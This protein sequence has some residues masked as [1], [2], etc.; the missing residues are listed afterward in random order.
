MPAVLNAL[1][2]GAVLGFSGSLHCACMCGS[3]ASGGLFLLPAERDL[4]IR[5]LLFSQA[6]RV[7]TYSLLGAVSASI[8]TTL[9]GSGAS[10]P[11]SAFLRWLGGAILIAA[12]LS[13]AK[14]MPQFRFAGLPA[15]F[16]SPLYP[17]LVRSRSLLV[18][19]TSVGFAWGLT[20]CP[21]VYAALLSSALTWPP[22]LAGVFMFG[23]GLGTMPSVIGAAMATGAVRQLRQNSVARL[24]GGVAIAAVGFASLGLDLQTL[25]GLCTLR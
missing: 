8:V 20:P 14:I 23:F 2:T 6:G 11:V 21:L 16:S 15:N 22:V 5:A 10:L 9:I 13:M 17:A 3:I 25:P 1:A 12:G 4:K 19:S 7:L 24:I 18:A